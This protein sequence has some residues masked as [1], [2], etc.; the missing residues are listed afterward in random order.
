KDLVQLITERQNQPLRE[1]DLN[2][3]L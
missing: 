3:Y 1:V 2:Q